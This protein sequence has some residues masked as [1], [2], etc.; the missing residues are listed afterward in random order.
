MPFAHCLECGTSAMIDPSGRCPEGH[1]VGAAGA[2]VA[3]AI[4]SSTPH[5]DEPQPWVG[6]VEAEGG[7][8]PAED[9]VARP[10]PVPGVP[11]PPAGTSSPAADDLLRELHALGD[12]AAASDAPATPPTATP[13]PAPAAPAPA[14][15]APAPAP[16]APP[17]PTPPS[18]ADEATDLDA[19]ANLAAA[20]RSLDDR[21]ADAPPAGSPP[22]P[23]AM[24]AGGPPPPPSAANPAAPV[25]D[26]H[27]PSDR[28]GR[29]RRAAT[30][31][32]V[33]VR[34]LVHRPR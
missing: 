26:D 21:G 31:A 30:A 32:A 7:D 11:A 34:R 16:A 5:P 8:A 27:A 4:G 18:A 13:A 15:A 19:L 29:A 9:R 6:V 3:A 24:T 2:R 28:R 25:A 17:T 33:A 20:V 1:V 14:P 23:A 22:P 10:K 12:L